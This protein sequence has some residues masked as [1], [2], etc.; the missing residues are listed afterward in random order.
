MNRNALIDMQSEFEKLNVRA[1]QSAFNDL[2]DDPLKLLEF[3]K[4]PDVHMQRFIAPDVLQ[5]G[6]HFHVRVDGV[7]S[8]E[9]QTNTFDQ[10]VFSVVIDVPKEHKDAVIKIMRRIPGEPDPPGND[11]C[12]KCRKCAIAIINWV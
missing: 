9:D 8:P 11:P 7:L 4:G 12:K 10:I 5:D 3:V 2:A 6:L 1:I